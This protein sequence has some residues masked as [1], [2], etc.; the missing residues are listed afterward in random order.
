MTK[1]EAIEATT[2]KTRLIMK[3]GRRPNLSVTLPKI[4]NPTAVPTKAIA[5]SAP[6][7]ALSSW[8]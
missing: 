7:W 8:K 1:A 5:V 3:T 6:L 4:S 2:K